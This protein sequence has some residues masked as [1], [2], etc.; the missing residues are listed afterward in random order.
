MPTDRI[1]C[2]LM[3]SLCSC[4]LVL[5]FGAAVAHACPLVDSLVDY[6]CDGKHVISVVGDSIV[7]GTG[8]DLN[9]D[10][11]GYPLRLQRIFPK[12]EVNSFGYR[13]ITTGQLISYYK[14]LFAKRGQN[15]EVRSLGES[16][17]VIV[18]VG[19]N[20]YFN[21]N[22]STLT[23]TTIKRLILTLS[24]ELGKRYG[25]PP[26][27]ASTV[28]PLTRREI[29][30]GFIQQVNMVLLRIR[31][32][33]FPAFLRFDTLSPQL[34]GVDGLHPTSSGYDVLAGITARY[35]NTDAQRRSRQARKDTDG[36]GIY[37]I[38]ERLKFD[39]SPRLVDTDGD[40][41]PDGEE[42]FR[43]K[44]DQL[45]TDTD[46]DGVGD[47]AEVVAGSDPLVAG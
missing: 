25:S 40:N 35:I 9:G 43:Y 33:E 30:L 12:S 7:F 46:G 34:L 4:L 10:R 18:D 13:G 17:V 2:R 28:L 23:A 21:R 20:D 24:T 38:F 16:D 42:V 26:L 11:G 3:T 47:G 41:L 29:D 44:T 39:T 15:A 6:N 22:S 5:N 8:D 37:D 32:R 1:F 27:F 19:R 14:R 36:D 45:L 31:G